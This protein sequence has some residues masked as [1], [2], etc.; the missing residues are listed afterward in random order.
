MDRWSKSCGACH[1]QWKAKG[2]QCL[3]CSASN[4]ARSGSTQFFQISAYGSALRHVM[5]GSRAHCTPQLLLRR[6]FHSAGQSMNLQDFEYHCTAA[7]QRF[8][9]QVTG[10]AEGAHQRCA[11]LRR[12]LL[13]L[14]C[15]SFQCH[16]HHRPA[17]LL[18]LPHQFRVG[19]SPL[20]QPPL[21]LHALWG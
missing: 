7:I 6:H 3:P 14:L 16:P 17:H 11:T 18:P 9:A 8:E 12:L 19:H 13:E 2:C 20:K 15:A 4:L 10:K 1:A 5:R 21:H